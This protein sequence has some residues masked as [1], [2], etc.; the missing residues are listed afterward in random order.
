MKCHLNCTQKAAQFTIGTYLKRE[1]IQQ[2]LYHSEVSIVVG[3]TDTTI[4]V[5]D[6][7]L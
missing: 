6:Q 1:H 5:K 3:G 2:I 7:T 4:D